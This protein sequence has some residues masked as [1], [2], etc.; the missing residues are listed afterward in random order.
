MATMLAAQLAQIAAKSSNPLDLK[1]QKQAHSQSL[2]F[3]PHIAASQG[4]ETIYQICIEGY[5][6]LC[7]LDQRFAVYSRSIF[8]EQSRGEERL[9]MTAAQNKELDEVVQSFLGLVGARLLLKPALKAIEWLVRRFR[10]V[11]SLDMFCS[12]RC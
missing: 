8:S 11:S 9:Q 4:F 5:L 3:E 6:E 1:A 2:L 7:Q 12:C 10:S